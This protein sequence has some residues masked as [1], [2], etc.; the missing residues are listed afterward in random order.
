VAARARW[1][2]RFTAERMVR[3]TEALYLETLAEA[4]R[5]ATGGAR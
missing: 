5:A 2:E 4:G 3:E 1:Q